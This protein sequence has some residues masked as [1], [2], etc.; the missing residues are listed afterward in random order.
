MIYSGT[1]RLQSGPPTSFIMAGTRH[2]SPEGVQCALLIQQGDLDRAHE[3]AQNLDTPEGSFWHGIMHRREPD[4]WNAGYWFR[5]VGKHPI[6]PALL[7]TVSQIKK[8]YPEEWLPLGDRW[9][10]FQWIDF[11][12]QARVKPGSEMERM[13]LEIQQTEWQLLHDWCAGPTS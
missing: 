10:P 7:E 1:D 8:R 13:A 12:E 5:K 11:W 4:A 3:I 9:D 2:Y 6:F